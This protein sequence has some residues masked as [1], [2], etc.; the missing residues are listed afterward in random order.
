ME[1]SKND[2]Q[3]KV[4]TRLRLV[5]FR[6]GRSIHLVYFTT[7]DA[8]VKIIVLIQLF[9]CER[10]R[11]VFKW[12]VFLPLMK[13]HICGSYWG[14]CSTTKWYLVIVLTSAATTTNVILY[15]FT[16]NVQQ[17]TQSKGLLKQWRLKCNNGIK[18][19][20]ILNTTLATTNVRSIFEYNIESKSIRTC[21]SCCF[22]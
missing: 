21:N 9:Y 6:G 14:K 1:L 11:N 3:E 2:L 12:G 16:E 15:I 4:A 8:C 17:W 7:R 13:K 18:P 5:L 10:I 22:F 20:C 19:L